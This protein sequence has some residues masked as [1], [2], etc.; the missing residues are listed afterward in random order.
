MSLA[1]TTR[2]ATKPIIVLTGSSMDLH[3]LTSTVSFL[4]VATWDRVPGALRSH[5]HISPAASAAFSRTSQLLEILFLLQG[6]SQIPLLPNIPIQ[7]KL[8]WPWHP[9]ALYFCFFCTL[10]VADTLLSVGVGHQLA[11]PTSSQR[12]GATSCRSDAAADS[13]CSRCP[14]TAY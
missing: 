7:S 12:A 8:P 10:S 11:C 4:S 9:L 6:S 2:T 3:Y 13:A 5:T 14:L 1:L